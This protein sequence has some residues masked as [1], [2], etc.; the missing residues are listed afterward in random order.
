M[1]TR[2]QSF[3]S[4]VTRFGV[5][6]PSGQVLEE[7]AA[8]ERTAGLDQQ[9]LLVTL[10]SLA[11][12]AFA[13]VEPVLVDSALANQLRVGAEQ[14]RQQLVP[15]AGDLGPMVE[16][17]LLP[18]VQRLVSL[19]GTRTDKAAALGAAMAAMAGFHSAQM[20]Q[21]QEMAA[22]LTRMR[23][24]LSELAAVREAFDQEAAE[25]V[26]THAATLAEIEGEGRSKIEAALAEFERK[27]EEERRAIVRQGVGY[28]EQA[29][30]ILGQLR[31]KLGLAADGSLSIGYQKQADKEDAAAT[32]DKQRAVQVG[33]ASA[34]VGAA[35]LVMAYLGA[36][37]KWEVNRW[38]VLPLKVGLVV[39]LGLIAGYLASQSASHRRFAR[40]LRLTSLELSNIGAYL[41]DLTP[42]D[43][44]TQR[45]ELVRLFFGKQPPE[46]TDA[47][48][49]MSGNVTIPE[50]MEILR[51]VPS[52]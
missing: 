10:L 12:A 23:E 51:K 35:A 32:R 19:S 33:V 48:P 16:G 22:D 2:R 8:L 17:N 52:Q 41:A 24:E 44:A 31:E 29:E 45:A 4:L 39:A 43:R 6:T 1:A 21:Q 11:E 27:A 38:E 25:R 13:T 42:E 18:Q 28:D 37:R 36:A 14:V 15:G 9:P 20:Q 40:Q 3:E 30:T 46:H 50:L 5:G 47:K 34:V 26:E 7:L 49:T